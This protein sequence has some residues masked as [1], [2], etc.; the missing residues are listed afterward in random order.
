MQEENLD[1]DSSEVD[2]RL[3]MFKRMRQELNQEE[4]KNK[5]EN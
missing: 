1:H 2:K 3:A 5:E 4:S